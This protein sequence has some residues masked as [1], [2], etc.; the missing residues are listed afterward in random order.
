MDILVD[1]VQGAP[2]CYVLRCLALSVCVLYLWGVWLHMCVCGCGVCS[3][4]SCL[5]FII[6]YVLCGCCVMPVARV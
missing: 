5:F 1:F 6:H 2:A 3:Q 4:L